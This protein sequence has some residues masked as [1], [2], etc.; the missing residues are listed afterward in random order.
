M[1]SFLFKSIP[2]VIRTL[3]LGRTWG[4]TIKKHYCKGGEVYFTAN[5][6]RNDGTTNPKA[7]PTL[8]SAIVW[9]RGESQYEV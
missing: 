7:F 8:V 1:S 5:G 9:T 4:F 3:R 2:V 6:T